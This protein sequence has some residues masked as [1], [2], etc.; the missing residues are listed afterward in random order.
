MRVL[1]CFGSLVAEC[2][3]SDDDEPQS[4]IM[5]VHLLTRAA[6]LMRWHLYHLQ[7]QGVNCGSYE[8]LQ[9]DRTARAHH[10][11]TRAIVLRISA[12]HPAVF[13]RR[14]CVSPGL[15]GVERWRWR[16]QGHMEGVRSL[17]AELHLFLFHAS[18]VIH[19]HPW[20]I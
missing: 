6:T 14:R 13:C 1:M 15:H 20:R 5:F 10:P 16:G 4:D 12:W 7:W 3:T 19:G 2:E 18:M 11:V 17:A 8:R 9:A